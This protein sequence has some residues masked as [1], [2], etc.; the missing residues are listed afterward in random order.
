LV[1]SDG[2]VAVPSAEFFLTNIMHTLYLCYFGLREPLVQTQVLPYLRELTRD[3]IQVTLL[4][5]E[6]NRRRAW[7]R[8]AVAD[9]TQRLAAEGIHW[10]SL[11][12]HK[13]P[14]LPATVF[15]ILVGGWVASR[16]ARRERV[17][18]LHGRSHIGAAIGALAKRL[19]RAQLLFDI[20]GILA[21]EYV[22]AGHWKNGGLKFRLLKTA[23]KRIVE[24]TDAFVVLTER[25]RD[26]FFPGCV[27]E[28]GHGHPI[29]VIPCCID[30]DRFNEGLM[31]NRDAL[32][33]E[34]GADGRKILV[35]VGALGGLYPASEMAEFIAA[36]RRDDSST[37]AL[38]LTQSPPE[39]L[40]RHLDR[41][42]IQPRDYLIRK[43]PAP[44]VPSYLRASDVALSIKRQ[45]YSQ[46]FCSPTKIPEYLACGLPVISST[47]IGDTDE[48][49]TQE[50]VGVV[51]RDFTEQDY[52]Q[53]LRAVEVLRQDD[54]LAERCREVARRRFDLDSIGGT[55][56]RRLYQRL[57]EKSPTRVI[58]SA[59]VG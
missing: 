36:A 1:L 49:L 33:R 7:T 4:T 26:L 11:P 43:V 52:L 48:L 23:E 18:V 35:Y 37:F 30:P 42:G 59:G 44:D 5:F 55:R 54:R 50:R 45:G 15:D 17:D 27:D 34:I 41:L 32:R 19:C 58:D 12:Y 29:E 25:G 56:Y 39:L 38:V 14:S 28:D 40:L 20:R 2:F 3:G 22:D 53:A 57:S 10:R 46:A 6:P 16:I 21:E 31:P 13:R 9:W 47:G 24:A 8:E 51:F